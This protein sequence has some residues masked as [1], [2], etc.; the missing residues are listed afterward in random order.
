[1]RHR[2]LHLTSVI[3]SVIIPSNTMGIIGYL[4][5]WYGDLGIARSETFCICSR[6]LFRIVRSQGDYIKAV[7]V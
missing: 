3:I 1:M 5:Y 7:S 6:S 2:L 4:F